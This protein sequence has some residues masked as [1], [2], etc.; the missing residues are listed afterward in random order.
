MWNEPGASLCYD[1]GLS[2]PLGIVNSRYEQASSPSNDQYLENPL[3]PFS[4]NFSETIFDSEKEKKRPGRKS[5]F[6][7]EEEEQLT[8]L[9]SLYGETKWSLIAS[10]MPKWNRKQLREHYV[11]YIKDSKIQGK[12]TPAEDSIIL[13]HVNEFGHTWKQLAQKLPGRSPITIK[14]RYYKMLI[15]KKP[16]KKSA[17]EPGTERISTGNSSLN[18]RISA[19]KIGVLI[20]LEDDDN[21]EINKGYYN[22]AFN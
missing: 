3:F 6:S 15:K 20:K 4:L 16:I 21:Q 5:N 18:E 19:D 8:R 9:V 2:S 1:P 13:Q 11:N 22:S 12:F 17:K 10:L 7:P 14:N